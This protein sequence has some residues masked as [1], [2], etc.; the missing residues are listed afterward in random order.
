MLC[1]DN[2]LSKCWKRNLTTKENTLKKCSAVREKE[3]HCLWVTHM[4]QEI[5]SSVLSTLFDH[6]S[7]E[8]HHFYLI[9]ASTSLPSEGQDSTDSSFNSINTIKINSTGTSRDKDERRFVNPAIEQQLSKQRRL[10]LLMFLHLPRRLWAS[11][12]YLDVKKRDLR[13]CPVL[14]HLQSVLWEP[15]LRLLHAKIWSFLLESR[16]RISPQSAAAVSHWF[17]WVILSKECIRTELY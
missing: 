4:Q 13:L 5:I 11:L 15:N 17:R 16:L 8:H 2:S 6:R 3:W 7:Q 1:K 10:I 9:T 14:R 12:Q